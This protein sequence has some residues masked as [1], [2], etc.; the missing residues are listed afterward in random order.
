MRLTRMAPA[1]FAAAIFAAAS[2]NPSASMPQSQYEF[3]YHNYAEST[4]ILKVLAARHPKL[5]RLHSIGRSATGTKE[6]WC[7]EIGNQE[8]GPAED[9]P[10]IYFDGNQHSSEVMGGEVTLYLAWHLLSSYGSDVQATEAVDTRVTYIVQRADPDGAE[11]YMTGKID[12]NNEGVQ[13]A[14]DADGDGQKGEDGPEDIDGDGEILRMRIDDP[15]GGWKLSALDPRLMVE[16]KEGDKTGP[17]YRVLDEGID[18]D[19]DGKVNEDPPFTRFISN[20]NYPAFWASESARFRGEG[21]YPLEEHNARLVADF[22]VSRP[23][24]SQVESYHTTSGIHL[25]PY[26]ARPDA[27]FPPQDLQDYSAILAKGMELTSYPAA[28]VYNDFTTIEPG[29]PPDEQPGIR[30]GVFVDWTYVHRG[31]FS[32]TTELWTLEPFVNE[33]GWG[34]IPRDRYLFAIPGRYNRPD[35]Q[36][37]MLQWLD[38][39]RGSPELGGQGFVDWKSYRHPTLGNVEIGGFTRYWLRNP[40]PGPYFQKVAADQARYAV[41]R[42]LTTPLARIQSVSVSPGAGGGPWEVTATVA[43]VGYLDTSLQQARIAG[44]ARA[45]RVRI[46][47]PEGA[48]TQDPMVVEFPFLRGKRGSAYESLYRAVWRIRAEAGAE[49]GVVLQS[50]KGGTQRSRVTLG[51][52]APGSGKALPIDPVAFCAG[53]G[54]AF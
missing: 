42:I 10:A 33:A 29:L 24:I 47:L 8:T 13:G 18:N 40:A 51:R 11:A 54:T 34:E 28:S 14:R 39:H 9:K 32:V 30:H 44:I 23:H 48:T 2:D 5:A 12:W 53:R 21:N 35:V 38:R 49:V 46:D 52:T 7:I 19:G 15:N 37:A 17:F 1:V 22:I 25:R 31:L 16:R 20:R 36:A 3:R 6:L 41:V 50:E 4:A 26:A 43:N 45:D 27:D